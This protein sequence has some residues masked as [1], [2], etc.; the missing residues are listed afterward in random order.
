M[1]ALISKYNPDVEVTFTDGFFHAK[2]RNPRQGPLGPP[3]PYIAV[4]LITGTKVRR[5]CDGVHLGRRPCPLKNVIL[6]S[7]KELVSDF[8][9]SP[10]LLA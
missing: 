4:V 3:V 5:V 8:R 9:L 1:N 10:Q 2:A 6:V 7:E